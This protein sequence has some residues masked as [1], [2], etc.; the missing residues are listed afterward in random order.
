MQRFILL[1]REIN[2]SNI[3]GNNISLSVTPRK[4][5][6]SFIVAKSPLDCFV[7]S[8][9]PDIGLYYIAYNRRILLLQTFK[10]FFSIVIRYQLPPPKFLPNE[11]ITI[12]ILTDLQNRLDTAL[13][14]KIFPLCSVL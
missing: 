8:I 14:S 13:N 3:Y 10:Q 12:K 6:N 11:N 4:N 9:E 1:R 7:C 5:C 2:S